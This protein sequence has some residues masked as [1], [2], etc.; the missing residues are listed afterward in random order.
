MSKSYSELIKIPTFKERFEYLKLDGLVGEQTFGS[1]RFWNQD[2]Y[3]SS[4]WRKFRR[5]IIIRDEGCD[6]GF[7]GHEIFG[8][9]I[10]VHHIQP[11]TK[12][13][14]IQGSSLLLDPNN[15]I[16]CSDNTHKAIHYGDGNL[17]IKSPKF[18]ERTKNDTI[19]WKNQNG[20][21]F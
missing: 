4:Q 1:I 21:K 10:S 5:E 7:V 2:F 12:D 3:R 11:I 8:R 13:M 9:I 19:P 20:I 14:F 17:L 18:I 15:A 6:L 16:C